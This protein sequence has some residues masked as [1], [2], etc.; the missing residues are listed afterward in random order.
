MAIFKNIQKNQRQVLDLILHE[1]LY[2]IK[3]L[4]LYLL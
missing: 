3:E 2:N 4:Q 1:V